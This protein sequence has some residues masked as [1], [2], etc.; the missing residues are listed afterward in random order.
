M[1]EFLFKYPVSIFSKGEFVLLGAW[2]K[3]VLFLLVIARPRLRLRLLI[4][5]AA[6]P[7]RRPHI[8]NWRAG[9]IWLLQFARGGG[10]GAAV[11]A[12]DHRRRA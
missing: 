2:P 4:R 1:F 11:A 5:V 8:R 7:A 6:C 10:A 12:R 9:V 3:W